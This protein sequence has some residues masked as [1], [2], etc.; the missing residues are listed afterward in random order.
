MGVVHGLGPQRGPWTRS[1][2]VV[3][4]PGFHVLYDMQVSTF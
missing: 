2:E 3:Y 4:G 1:T